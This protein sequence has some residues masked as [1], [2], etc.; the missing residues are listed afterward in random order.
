M[1]PLIP[2]K[3]LQRNIQVFPDWISTVIIGKKEPQHNP[4]RDKLALIEKTTSHHSDTTI[5]E[6]L[7]NKMKLQKLNQD[8]NIRFDIQQA[9]V[10][11]NGYLRNLIMQNKDLFNSDRYFSHCSIKVLPRA[12]LGKYLTTCCMLSS[13]H[14]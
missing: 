11:I 2:S 12:E 9:V 8:L 13:T 10:D 1:C 5:M 3:W 14:S 4:A 7:K 6:V